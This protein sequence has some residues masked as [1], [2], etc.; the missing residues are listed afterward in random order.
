VLDKLQP[1]GSTQAF[2]GQ[3]GVEET[4]ILVLKLIEHQ[5]EGGHRIMEHHIRRKYYFLIASLTMFCKIFN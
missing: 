2:I 5:T 1:V 4:Y 3:Y